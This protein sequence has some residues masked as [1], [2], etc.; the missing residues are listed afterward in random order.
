MATSPTPPS[1]SLPTPLSYDAILGQMLSSYAASVGVNDLNVGSAST[2]FFQVVALMV[3]RSSGDVF[4]ILRDFSLDRATGPALQNLAIEYGVPP[5]GAAV[6]TGFV[7][8]TDL[9]FTK[10]FTQIYAG[11]NPPIA[12]STTIYVSNASNFPS[13]G[14]VYIGRGSVNVEGPLPYDLVTQIGSYWSLTLT[15][16]T[17]KYH[18]ISESVILSQGGVRTVPVN[19]I[20][21]SPGIG[22]TPTIQY[23]VSQIGTIL[24]GETTISN[25]PITALLPGSVAN[26]PAGAISQFSGNP[27]GLPNASVTNPLAITT[28]QDTEND[29]ELRI[30]VKN[31]L[32]S[33]GLGTVTAIESALL[34]VQ[35]PTSSDTIVSTDILNSATNTTVFIDNGAGLEATHTGVAIETIVNSAL[36]GEKF[37]QLVTGGKQT[38]V[39]KAILQ[40]VQAE[41]FN[42]SGGEVLTVVVGNITYNHTFASTDFANPGSATGYEVCASINGD[43]LLNYEAV[44]AGGGT[45]VV[46]R[47]EDEVTNTIQVTTPASSLVIDANT[48]L[49]FPS[50]KAETLQLYKNGLL[51]TEDGTTA[52]IFTQPQSLWSPSLATGETLSLAIDGTAPITFTLTNAMFVAEGTYTTLSYSNSLQSWVNV[53]NANITGITASI[54][55]STIEITSNL[56]AI[57]RAQ[58]TVVNT[59]SNPTS[60][61]S[62]GFINNTDLTSTGVASDYILDRNTA[63]IELAKDLVKNDVLS[64]GTP[65]T[66]ANIK[67]GTVP[68]GSVTLTSDAHVWISIDTNAMIIPTIQGGSTLSVS[69]IAPNIIRYTTNSSSA[70]SN[71]LPGDYVIVWSAEIP[72]TD[73]LEGRV[74]ANTGDTLDIEVTV[75]EYSAATP[76]SNAPFIQGFVVVRTKNV[77]QKFTVVDA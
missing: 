20:V 76:I 52:S 69:K 32:A 34:G 40:T 31:K 67:I 21:I 58:I 60:L 10:I 23:F 62:K 54:V 68:S 47:P 1:S 6:A 45:F 74:H 35:S 64:A 39:T 14:A 22:T 27:S 73:D 30:R 56:G 75:A 70:F 72:A 51:L 50:Q 44:T 9:S 18:N 66:Q 46:I 63:Q 38:S 2:G 4:Q 5:I 8:I 16:P 48:I 43:T 29:N 57:D 12:G 25:V 28:G 77:P 71:V 65:I 15:S 41:P 37:F 19:T 13:S 11:Q 17:T 26:V 7:T 42:L 36:G 59:I 49:Q 33:T 61:I 24:D 53:L 3:A 55:G